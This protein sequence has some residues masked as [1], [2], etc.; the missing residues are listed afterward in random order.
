MASMLRR[1][2]EFDMMTLF[3][4]SLACPMERITPCP[5][6]EIQALR[7]L[8]IDER[9]PAIEKMDESKIAGII[10]KHLACAFPD[11]AKRV[12]KAP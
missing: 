7:G 9:M 6:P 5:L 8:S 11:E 12:R 3:G 4:L 1:S 2:Q 10:D